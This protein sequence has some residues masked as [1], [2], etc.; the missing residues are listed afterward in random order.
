MYQMQQTP[1][2]RTLV[3]LALKSNTLGKWGIDM[4]YRSSYPLSSR[5]KYYPVDSTCILY[6][7]Y[8]DGTAK[9][10]S[11]Y[12]NHGTLSGCTYVEKGLQFNGSTDHVVIANDTELNPPAGNFDLTID[13][14]VNVD[15]GV[16]NWG[17]AVS[18]GSWGTGNYVLG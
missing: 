14:W 7:A 13:A 2:P 4:S 11:I 18:K 12:D 1:M 15:A 16:S 6:H 5:K 17:F 10:H 3:W 8:W 9:D